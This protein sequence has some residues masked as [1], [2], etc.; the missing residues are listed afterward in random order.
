MIN[1]I[2]KLEKDNPDLKVRKLNINNKD[3]FIIYF[4]TLCNSYSINEFI[5]FPIENNNIN[6][7][8]KILT[9]LPSSNLV[10]IKNKED[11]LLNLYS[12][13]TIIYIDNTFISFE[14][15]ERLNSEISEASNEKTVK[16]PKD[17]FTENYQTNL[18][19]IRKRIRS[20]KLIIKEHNIGTKSKTKVALIYMDDI[21]NKELVNKIEKKINNISIDY[22]P[23]SNYI[24]ELIEKKNHTFPNYIMTERPDLVS[25]NLMNGRIAIL[26]ENTIE[27]VIIPTFFNDL[28][29]SIDD[30]YQNTKN[31]SVTRII[32]LI[33]FIL[34]ILIPGLYIAL[35]TFN[36]ETLPTSILINFSIQRSGV[37]FPSI[38]EALLLI[39]TF[40]LLREA[41]TRT[42][43]VVGTSMSILGALV[44][45]EAAVSAGL[46][47]PIMII[48]IAISSIASFL[49]NDVDVVNSIRI[50]KIIILLLSSFLGLYGL[51]IGALLFLINI[52]SIYSFGYDY[53]L[54]AYPFNK[55]EQS[56]NLILTKKYKLN[57]RN[58]FLTKNTKRR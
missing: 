32:R 25:F 5:L 55:K 4:E 13:F 47:S 37:P 15:K 42:P 45:G 16:G 24:V 38:V 7:V 1:I 14:T 2:N 12:G 20:D 36:P 39:L 28:I 19:L 57:F 34:S 22:I 52:C 18:G 33:A 23:N 11:L 56:N 26:V 35:T 31:V 40:E 58:M 29:K 48:V 49:F 9:K 51:F 6:S 43:L 44:L 53:T 10:N 46:I 54:P 50:W 17:S 41:D 3:I 30:Y 21:T 8:N 27:V